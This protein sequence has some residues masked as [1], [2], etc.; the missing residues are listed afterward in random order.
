MAGSDRFYTTFENPE[1]LIIYDKAVEFKF[2]CHSSQCST[3]GVSKA[4]VHNVLCVGRCM[5]KSSS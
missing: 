1:I 3:T 5:L 4:M 2:L